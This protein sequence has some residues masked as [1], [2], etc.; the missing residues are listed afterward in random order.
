MPDGRQLLKI[1][2]EVGDWDLRELA[3]FKGIHASL[4]LHP[5]RL[6]LKGILAPPLL[7]RA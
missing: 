2:F 4:D 1:T 7:Q 6:E 3:A 5:Q